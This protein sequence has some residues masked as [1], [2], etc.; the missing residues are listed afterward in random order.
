MVRKRKKNCP[1]LLVKTTV[2]LKVILNEVLGKYKILP[3]PY[4]IIILN[5]IQ[6]PVQGFCN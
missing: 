6:S 4:K 5:D 2:D 1:V 3:G